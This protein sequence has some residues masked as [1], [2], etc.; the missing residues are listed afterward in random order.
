MDW[1]IRP[2]RPPQSA[3]RH[4]GARRSPWAWLVAPG[5]RAG[6]LGLAATLVLLGL[7]VVVG[8]VGGTG[9]SD[10]RATVSD[11]GAHGAPTAGH[12]A[13][14]PDPRTPT[15]TPSTG[16]PSSSSSP[17]PSAARSASPEPVD[18]QPAPSSPQGTLDNTSVDHP[19]HHGKPSWADGGA[20][21]DDKPG[22][23]P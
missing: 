6:V 10:P 11:E 9:R 8:L 2:S 16:D 5:R 17:S 13:L 7:V 22:V 21:D 15:P 14:P 19:P 3:C 12:R 1:M 20:H 18:Q 23:S 4:R